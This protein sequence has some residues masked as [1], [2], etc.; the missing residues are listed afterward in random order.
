MI[1]LGQLAVLVTSEKSSP[2]KTARLSI[3]TVNGLYPVAAFNKRIPPR[4]HWLLLQ[5][6]Q[7]MG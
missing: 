2:E 7:G 6:T 1:A 5:N 4:I 3:Y